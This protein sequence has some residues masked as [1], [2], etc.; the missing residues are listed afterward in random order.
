MK[1][2]LKSKQKPILITIND[3]FLT[4]LLRKTGIMY[5]YINYLQHSTISTVILYSRQ[6]QQCL[7]IKKQLKKKKIKEQKKTKKAFFRIILW[8]WIMFR[9]PALS[10]LCKFYLY[11]NQHTKEFIC[12]VHA[13]GLAW[14][15]VICINLA[16][17]TTTFYS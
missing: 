11:N 9:R 16:Y 4:F 6:H 15:L 1:F 13:C 2:T 5:F 3:I 14:I 17:R 12:A 8:L 10:S 7:Y